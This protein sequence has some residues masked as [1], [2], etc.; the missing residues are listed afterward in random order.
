MTDRINLATTLAANEVLIAPSMLKCDYAHL[1]RD[2]ALLESAGA[3]ILHWDV[4][5]GHFVPNLSYGAM[6]IKQL[7]DCTDLFFDTHL[8]ISEPERYLDSY[9]DAGSDA[10]TIHI[11]AV[12]EPTSLLRT[13]RQAGVAA[14]LALNPGTPV[15]QVMPFV[16]EC[17]LLLVMSVEP[18]FGGQKFMPVALEKLKSFKS[19]LPEQVLL[20][21][22][23]G[24]DQQTISAAAEAGANVFVAGSSIFVAE[25][26]QSSLLELKSQ[27]K[28]SCTSKCG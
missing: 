22:D 8:M 23:G 16:A 26:Y 20:S 11:E 21:I 10:I 24:I 1:N 5:D 28:Q 12:A 13:I 6:L 15:E 4:M 19:K 9:L 17:D 27:A 2:V 18:G 14:G 25:D 7:R 3:K